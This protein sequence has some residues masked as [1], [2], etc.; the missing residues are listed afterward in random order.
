M[1]DGKK[2]IVVLGIMAQLGEKSADLH[3]SVGKKVS[4]AAD[5]VIIV[6]EAD[7]GREENMRYMKNAEEAAKE[8]RTIADRN[9]VFLC[10]GSQIAR[11]EKV[12]KELLAPSVDP[13]EVLVR[14][15]AGWV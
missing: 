10:K 2:K 3:R 7:Y 4:A 5:T 15:D 12:V 9:T 6:G 11:I 13:K 14:Q 8:C 1:L